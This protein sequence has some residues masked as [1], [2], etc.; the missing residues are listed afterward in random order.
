[1][2]EYS[3]KECHP[4]W[5][6]SFLLT[7]RHPFLHVPLWSPDT[8][9][10]PCKGSW[11]LLC[12]VWECGG[13][14]DITCGQPAISAAVY[15]PLKQPSGTPATWHTT[16]NGRPC[17][18]PNCL[19]SQLP[20]NS[21]LAKGQQSLGVLLSQS[22]DHLL[23]AWIAFARRLLRT[24][25]CGLCG[26]PRLFLPSPSTCPPRPNASGCFW[27]LHLFQP[28]SRCRGMS[29]KFVSGA[30]THNKEACDFLGDAVSSGY[31]VS[32]LLSLRCPVA[33]R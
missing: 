17:H 19:P 31:R 9:P 4:K 12:L 16:S 2:C 6:T 25:V 14:E 10:H 18:L 30:K 20:E 26:A 27:S 23:Q 3:F 21:T 29:W 33:P 24:G 13:R 8:W 15:L 5:Q 7:G 22:Q 28:V 11:K 32:L 1:M